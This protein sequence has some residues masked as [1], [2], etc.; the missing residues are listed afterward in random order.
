[1]G[2]IDEF[3]NMYVAA[4]ELPAWFYA[5]FSSEVR[6]VAAV[7]PGGGAAMPDARPVAPGVTMRRAIEH[8]AMDRTKPALANHFWL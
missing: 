4:A 5:A 7:K 8:A 6:L 2:L 1:M 3:A